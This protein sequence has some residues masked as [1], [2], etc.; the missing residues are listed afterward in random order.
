MGARRTRRT[1][2]V[3]PPPRVGKL[4]PLKIKKTIVDAAYVRANAGKPGMKAL[5]DGRAAVF[6]DGV[7]TGGMHDQQHRT[8]HIAGAGNFPFT[9][10][11]DD[12]LMLRSPDELRALL[13]KAG[14]KPGDTI[15]GYCHIGQQMTAVLFA[16]RTLGHKVLLYDGSMQDWSRP[17]R[18]PGRRIPPRARDERASPRVTPIRISP[19]R[20]SG[21]VSCSP[22]SRSRPRPRRL[23]RL[24]DNRRRPHERGRAARAAA[25]PLFARYLDG[26]GPWRDWLL[27]RDRGVILGGFLSALLAGRL[28]AEVERGPRISRRVA[29]RVRIRRR[30]AMGL[31][32]VLARGCT[33]GLALTGG[34]LLSVG[35]WIFIG[36][37]FAAAYRIVAAAETGLAMIDCAIAVAIGIAFGSRSSA[38]A[39]A[40][41]Q[42]RRP[43]LPHRL[44]GLQS[45]VQRDRHGDA[46]RVL[47]RAPR[48]A[49]SRARLRAR[50]VAAPQLA[51]GLLFG[52]GFVVAGLCPGTSCVAAATGRGDGV[53]VVAR[54]VRRRARHRPRL[55]AAA[56]FYESTSARIADVAGAAARAVRRRGLRDRGDR[57]DRIS[58]RGMVERRARD[59]DRL[60]AV[61]ARMHPR[62]TRTVRR[63]PVSRALR[64]T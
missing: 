16:A 23:G 10:V 39:S 20:R 9:E 35:S 59:A 13:T 46:R 61:F 33:S 52:A 4:A 55:R 6:Y 15:L 29:H 57:A 51:G 30:R 26:D 32:A 45:D 37:A 49:R 18:L 8:G 58:R 14:V 34:A 12:D 60:L 54:H 5:V 47:A 64:S 63:Q 50:D 22:P 38:R 62:R 21:V 36:A 17:R 53:A 1:T 42:A 19:A 2:D 24:R 25:S 27:V 44:H 28:R 41:A 31:G 48:R 40:R 7:D 43:V 56:A 11:T 3:I